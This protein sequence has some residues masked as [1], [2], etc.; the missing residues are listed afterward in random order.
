MPATTRVSPYLLWPAV[1]Y[2]AVAML[3]MLVA[4]MLY[5]PAPE[6]AFL[7]DNSPV[8]WLSSAQL[9]ALA[10]LSL[11]LTMERSLPFALGLWLCAAMI[12]LAFDEQ[13]ML[14]ELWKYGCLNW[15]DACRHRWATEAPMLLVGMAGMAT[16]VWLHVAL[17]SR[18]ARIL[19]W[20][21]LAV[22]GLAIGVDL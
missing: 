6:V 2:F 14:H 21:S 17:R 5:W 18:T 16:A 19:L 15:W 20:C 12:V 8:S 7:S 1:C 4:A 13:F 22:A 9:W 3:F 10:L 11:R